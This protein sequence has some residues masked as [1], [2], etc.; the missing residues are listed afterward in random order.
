M[1]NDQPT[2]IVTGSSR[3]IGL[4]I[5]KKFV[6]EGY[7]VVLNSRHDL[8]EAPDTEELLSRNEQTHYIQADVS[9]YDQAAIIIKSA[10]SHFGRLDVLVNNAGINSD[11]FFHKMKPDQWRDVID[12]NLLGVIN[13]CHAAVKVFREQKSGSIINI[14]SIVGVTGNIGQTNYAASKAGL[15]GF[16]KS[17]ALELA[18]K[19]VR[20][21]AIC[22][23]FI[24]TQ[25]V[26]NMPDT[27]K[28][29]VLSKIPMNRFGKPS[30]IA[31]LAYFL[32]S[33]NGSYITGQAIHIN[34]GLY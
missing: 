23:G 7:N 20:V 6:N 16:T 25:M 30:E 1:E 3:G 5:A 12:T 8:S 2:V 29:R 17:L 11:K 27:T 32:A 14:S 24:D 10:I 18:L 31:D 28:E 13:C 15:L 26:T 34:G 9:N 21:N 22:P 4:A 19:K 33:K